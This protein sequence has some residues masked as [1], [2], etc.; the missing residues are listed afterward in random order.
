MLDSDGESSK[1][2]AT[3]RGRE[4]VSDASGGAMSGSRRSCCATGDVGRL[5]RSIEHEPAQ[6]VCF[7][8]LR[9][10]VP[11]CEQQQGFA[12]GMVLA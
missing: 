9:G 4:I 1:N 10:Q 7:A 6:F 8:L 12:D 2:I 3:T 5:S 11:L